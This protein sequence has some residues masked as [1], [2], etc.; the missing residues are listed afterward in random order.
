M[1]VTPEQAGQLV[2]RAR[3]GDASAWN[4]LVDAYVGMVW[5]I[6]R[7]HRLGPSDGGDV[8]QA[9]WLRLL[10]NIDRITD[11][12]RV[13]AWLATTARRE[14]LRVLRAGGRQVLVGDYEYL[15]RAGADHVEVDELLLRRE[16]D[17]EVRAALSGLPPR[18]RELLELLMA[19]E[20]LSYE[21]IGRRLDMPVGSIG[22]TRGRCLAKLRRLVES[23]RA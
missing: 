12:D 17:T 8:S 16:S 22:P 10:E 5:S 2:R 9:T 13:G 7:A 21:E 15:D 23:T 18:C 19:D 6:T 3:E 14:C 4:E 1:R 11:P 20:P